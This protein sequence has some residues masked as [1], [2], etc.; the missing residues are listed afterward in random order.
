M[1]P[2]RSVAFAT[3]ATP[4][5]SFDIQGSHAVKTSSF[6]DQYSIFDIQGN[7]A[8]KTSSFVDQYSIFVIQACIGPG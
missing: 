4:A 8:M 6:V 5:T 7:H 2:G 1:W 3:A